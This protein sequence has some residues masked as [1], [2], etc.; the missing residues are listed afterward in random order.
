M[1]D[2]DL[3]RRG[4]DGYLAVAT[5]AADGA[6]SE[7]VPGVLVAP[8]DTEALAAALV[9]LLSDRALVER[10]AGAARESARPWILSPEEFA[11]RQAELIERVVGG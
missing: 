9:E 5:G 4:I 8:G 10:L 11:E 2:G 7:N 3:R 1:G 6:G